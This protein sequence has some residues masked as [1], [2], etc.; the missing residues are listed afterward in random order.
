MLEY[1]CRKTW[2]NIQLR[3]LDFTESSRANIYFSWKDILLLEPK[4]WDW[5][6]SASLF[7]CYAENKSNS[8]NE[9]TAL[10][11]CLNIDGYRLTLCVTVTVYV[12]CL[13]W[14]KCSLPMKNKWCNCSTLSSYCHFSSL[15]RKAGMN[16][17]NLP[18]LVPFYFLSH[19]TY[20]VI[21]MKDYTEAKIFV[22]TNIWCFW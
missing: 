15:W 5:N 6:P 14:F 20:R 18:C 4:V 10:M 17:Q 8:N 16:Y 22:I 1:K 12:C 9:L 2:T 13:I 19:L 21:F 7:T 3:L 11:I